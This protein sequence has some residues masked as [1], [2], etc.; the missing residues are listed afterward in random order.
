LDEF[1]LRGFCRPED[2]VQRDIQRASDGISYLTMSTVRFIQSV[3][4][5]MPFGDFD[6]LYV[7]Y[8]TVVINCSLMGSFY[9]FGQVRERSIISAANILLG[10]RVPA[11]PY[12]FLNTKNVEFHTVK[13]NENEAYLIAG[14]A[15]LPSLPA[16]VGGWKELF[17]GRSS[18]ALRSGRRDER[19]P[20]F[21][22]SNLRLPE[23]PEKFVEQ[24]Y[25]H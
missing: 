3:E 23:P 5:D 7:R 24:L 20:A 17:R 19:R 15:R 1:A 14:G 18:A 10:D 4:N 9:G 25:Q 6:Q 12:A 22:L 13:H 21:Q 16:R 2:H 11:H 8:R